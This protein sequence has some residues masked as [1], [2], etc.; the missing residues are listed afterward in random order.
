VER[1][2]RRIAAGL[3]LLLGAGPAML[4]TLAPQAAGLDQ[5]GTVLLGAILGMGAAARQ[6]PGWGRSEVSAL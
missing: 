5:L 3:G 1:A 2:G 4:A 6:A